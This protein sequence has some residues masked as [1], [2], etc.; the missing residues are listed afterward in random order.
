MESYRFKNQ[1][2]S[3]SQSQSL[4]ESQ[5]QA[6]AKN[7]L[8]LPLSGGVS[9]LCLL[10][11]LDAQLNE[12]VAKQGRRAYE[13]IIVCVDRPDHRLPNS[14][15]NGDGNGDDDGVGECE[16]WYRSVSQRFPLH[17]YLP[18]NKVWEVFQTDALLEQDL[19][20]LGITRP[21]KVDG[22]LVD[23]KFYEHILRSASTVTSLHDLREILTRRLITALAKRHDCDT[24]LWG[25]SDSRLAAQVLSDVAKGRGGSVP[26]A[27]AD[28]SA[29]ATGVHSKYP[30]RDLFRSELET[31]A[32]TLEPLLETLKGGDGVEGPPV[33]IKQTSID[34][35]LDQYITSQ[36]GKYPSIMANVV[37]TAS[38]LQA[39][40]GAVEGGECRVC[41]GEIKQDSIG[42]NLCY[43]CVRMKQDI[44]R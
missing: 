31:Y 16:K 8:L 27:L 23:E 24:I 39:P 33:S 19:S 2:Q 10:Q 29:T 22:G 30:M 44:R 6:A 28:G 4:S 38:K 1:A 3:Q 20:H 11:V 34:A 18:L 36:G 42:Q 35:L 21:D 40:C 13:I 14:N 43:G 17:H 5:S 9:S 32:S 15:A 37:R 41:Q 26:A 7:R 25:H 12:Q